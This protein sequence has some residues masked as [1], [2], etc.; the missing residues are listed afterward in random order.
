MA[1]LPI[2]AGGAG[3]EQRIEAAPL[4]TGQWTHVAVAYGSGTAVLYAEGGLS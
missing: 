2:T 1:A 4:P 3:A